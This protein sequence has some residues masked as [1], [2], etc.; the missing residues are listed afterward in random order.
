[1][2]MKGLEP[3]RLSA[4]D[5][6]SGTATN[7]ATSACD[8]HSNLQF[9]GSRVMAPDPKSAPTSRGTN[10]ATSACDFHSFG[11]GVIG[12]DPKSAPTRRGTNYATSAVINTM[13]CFDC[14]PDYCLARP[15]AS[16]QDHQ[17]RHIRKRRAN[18]W[19]IQK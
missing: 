2:R 13:A 15:P 7:Y 9:H 5:P 12:P 8:F 14:A 10:Y 4:P 11:S 19:I 16:L 1:M 6:K 18:L 3:P 17:L